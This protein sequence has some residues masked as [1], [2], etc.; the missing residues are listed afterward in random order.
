MQ[1]GTAGW[2]PAQRHAGE[3]TGETCT[4]VLFIELKEPSAGGP[5]SGQRIGPA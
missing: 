2:L 1:A 3:N 4:H 5:S